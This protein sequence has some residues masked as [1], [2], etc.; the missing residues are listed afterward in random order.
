MIRGFTED[1]GE[2]NTV[3]T[4]STCI[5]SLK[6]ATR[7]AMRASVSVRKVK[8]PRYKFRVFYPQTI[9]DGATVRRAAFFATRAEAQAFAAAKELEVTNHG[10]RHGTVEYAERA[11][12]V[13]Y[14]KWAANRPDAPPLSALLEKA[15]AAHEKARPP[16][17][18]SQAIDARMDAVDRRKLSSRHQEDLRCRL[19]RFR[20][21]FGERQVADV[22]LEDVEAWLHSLN[23]SAVTWRNYARTVGSIFTLAVKRGY[24]TA[25]PLTGLEHPKAAVK[26]PCIL[27]PP[28]L[29]TLLAASAPELRPLL[30]LQAFCGLRRAEANRLSWKHI[31]LEGAKPYAELPSEVTKTN[32]RRVC[33]I[34]ACAVAWLKPLAGASAATLALTEGVYDN[35]LAV[36]ATASKITWQENLLRH[37]FGTYRLAETQN[38]ALVADEMGNSPAVV[39]THYQNITS[40]EQAEAWWR[41]FPTVAPLT[42]AKASSR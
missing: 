14:R 22:R 39:R 11:A 42:D 40:P 8:H 7:C 41:I 34:P 1:F 4:D 13:R 24:L 37:S 29:S 10:T 20:T 18:V 12:I 9:D 2:C 32:R 15:I 17:S 31:H 27:T 33:Y 6:S 3:V 26:A 16:L 35:R 25:S 21:K 36:A 5:H 28:E 19:A 23:V 38:A 30:I